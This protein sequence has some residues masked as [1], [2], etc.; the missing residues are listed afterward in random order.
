MDINGE[1]NQIKV[2][3]MKD[4]L[5]IFNQIE[6]EDG[7]GGYRLNY[8]KIRDIW[9]IIRISGS[10]KDSSIYDNGSLINYDAIVRFTKDIKINQRVEFNKKV[11]TI[12]N[13]TEVYGRKKFLQVTIQEISN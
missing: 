11:G 12:T 10:D 3:E 4:R 2:E 1:Q 9:A 7:L 13:I 8:I 6:S 5:S